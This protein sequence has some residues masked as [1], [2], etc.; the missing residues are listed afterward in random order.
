MDPDLYCEDSSDTDDV[1][2]VDKPSFSYSKKPSPKI[3][4]TTGK[5]KL[6]TSAIESIAKKQKLAD[7]TFSPIQT[8]DEV[9]LNFK[10]HLGSLEEPTFANYLYCIQHATTENTLTINILE[11]NP[12][13]N[14]PNVKKSATTFDFYICI[15]HGLSDEPHIDCEYCCQFQDFT[16]TFIVETKYHYFPF[17]PPKWYSPKV[18]NFLKNFCE[19]SYKYAKVKEGINDEAAKYSELENYA[20]FM[21][22]DFAD[23]SLSA[24]S[25]GKTSYVR[26]AILGFHTCGVRATLT[27]DST[28]LPQY[29]VLPQSIYDRLELACPLVILNRAPSIKDTCI[30][31]VEVLRN[32]DPMDFTIKINSYITEGLHADQD[33][34]ELTIF[35]I[36]HTG[37]QQPTHDMLMAIAELKKFSW[38][39]GMR[40]N[41]AYSPR[42]ECTQ[43]LKYI[44]HRYDEYFTKESPLWGALFGKPHEKYNM[45]MHL[46]SSIFPDEVDEFIFQ[47]SEFVKNLDVQ[48][49]NIEDLLNGTNSIKDVIDSGAKGEQL[50]LETYLK[51]LFSLNKDRI[52]TLT[53][54]FNNYISSGSEMSTNGAYQFLFL[55][56]INPIYMLYDKLFYNDRILMMNVTK[57]GAFASYLFNS[58]AC[59]FIFNHIADEKY[60]IF[61]A[62]SEVDD[63]IASLENGN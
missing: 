55:G 21:K 35:Y 17:P 47:V 57:H 28:L 26:N 54:N 40:H 36:K 39:Y 14:K 19:N 29:A 48:L 33:G 50:H 16:Y 15:T 12:K 6:K 5:R 44:L 61:V 46:G 32:P 4:T 23:G 45:L 38:K 60:N 20:Q 2:E 30:Y 31:A 34:D 53:A 10:T 11:L 24:L 27:I 63:Y 41:L 18:F 42:Y 59:I 22:N 9:A 43:Y 1:S 13:I 56:A 62:E 49:P 7:S 58:Q 8:T 52:K 37:A 25:T 51:N 3:T